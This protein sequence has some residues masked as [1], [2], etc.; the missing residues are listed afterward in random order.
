[1]SEATDTGVRRRI[2]LLGGFQ[3]MDPDGP[4]SLAGEKVQ[5]LLAYLLLHPNQ[6][7]PREVLAD[8]LFPE[9]PFSR[10]RRNL[11]TALSRMQNAIGSGWLESHKDFLYLDAGDRLWVDVWDFKRL[12]GSELENELQESVDLYAGD[13]VPAIYDDWIIPEREL[14]RNQYLSVL[15]KLAA[16]YEQ[17]GDLRSAL[18]VIRRLVLA[19]PIH[20]PAHADYL[21][22]LG[23]L[24]RYGEALSHYQYLR[25]LLQ[26][27][28][29]VEPIS[30]TKQVLHAIERERELATARVV[31][32]EKTAFVGRVRER[33]TALEAVELAFQGSGGIIAIEGE[34]G[35]GKSR[36]LREIAEGTRWRGGTF[37]QGIV[38][39]IPDASPFSPLAEA[40]APILRSLRGLQIEEL[41]GDK[42]MAAL[43]PLNPAWGE[44]ATLYK[45]PTGLARNRFYDALVPLGE[46]LARLT[47]VVIALDD[48]Q[49]AD[50]ALWESLD[51]L[52]K[53][54]ATN[55]GLLVVVY[56]RPG[57]E[58]TPGWDV[59]QAWDRAGFLKSISLDPLSIDEVAQL[60]RNKPDS[61]PAE[62][63]AWTGGNPF[64]I[65]E[66]LADPELGEHKRDSSVSHRLQTLSFSAKA[67]LES[68]A[69]VG[70]HVPYRLWIDISEMPPPVL[71]GLGDELV[72]KHLLHLSTDGCAFTH[73]LIRAEIYAGIEPERRRMLHQRAASAYAYHDSDNLRARA[74]HF[75]RAGLLREAAKT[76]RLASQQD[77][78]RFAFKEAQRGLE[79]ALSCMPELQTL[80][81]VET[82]LALVELCDIT[83]DLT[84]LE[85]A[86][87]EA[88]AG[89]RQFGN[90]N[91][92]FQTLLAAGRAADDAGDM[93]N[94]VKHIEEALSI[95][96]VMQDGQRE[97]AA[98]YKLIITTAHQGKL[99][100]A[101][102]LTFKA[103]E[104]SRTIED[105][106]FEGKLLR[107]VGIQKSEIEQPAEAMHWLEQSV[108]VFRSIGES[109]DM[110]LSQ[111]ILSLI[112]SELGMWDRSIELAHEL[113]DYFDASGA[114]VKADNA[115][116]NLIDAHLLTGN[117]AAARNIVKEIPDGG[118]SFGIRGVAT[119]KINLGL[120][121]EAEGNPKEAEKYYADA[122]EI[123]ESSKALDL[124][125]DAQH[126]LGQLL[127]VSGRYLEAIPLLE[128]AKAF[129]AGEGYL[130]ERLQS[131]AL[132]G[133]AYLKAGER[134]HAE[135]IM[136]N[137]WGAFQEGVPIGFQYQEWLWAVFQLMTGLGETTAANE[138]LHAAYQE[139]QR[140]A[141]NIGDPELRRGFFERV[142]LNHSIVTAYDERTNTL[143]VIR[144]PLARID[145][146]LGR[147]L[148]AD[149]FVVVEWTVNA[150]ED[151]A[152]SQKGE[153]RR[154]QVLRLLQEAEQQGAAP[155]D[156]DLATAL[157]VSRRTI[158]R[159]LKALMRIIP[160]PA[161]RKRKKK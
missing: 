76:Y 44:K 64:Y 146:P 126:D 72:A 71:A 105:K 13:L 130:L 29:G 2:F 89:A 103:L 32:E 125:A 1:M 116:L 16:I 51:V 122:I 40:L 124:V 5:S 84:R 9:A 65:T 22:L 57:I 62:V 113:I 151:E 41:L 12:A 145:S 63:Y 98:L 99:H 27:E 47:P 77:Q 39:E 104:L 144:V 109:Y 17:S 46:A 134:K 61:D 86:L 33:V 20:E 19:E 75:E 69:I 161:T 34:A 138:V 70:E 123:A 11:S 107:A 35:I 73:D 114:R 128:A 90:A 26:E 10:G 18:L 31:D 74:F 160:V 4:C 136:V 37:L 112:Y 38:G 50:S 28:L 66:W 15:E 59:V 82:N 119:V 79:R 45:L 100:D 85:S 36:F 68:A 8:L 30:E 120:I 148:E 131:E 7:I 102:A 92:L 157:G 106:V 133:L 48:V 58:N 143:R 129:R 25:K 137:A 91:L 49:W 52:A 156:D 121:A 155:T 117:P 3:I 53:S 96:R 127:L 88:L 6:T 42:T 67:A 87:S 60:T 142:P 118:V 83:G 108:Q 23:R 43:A 152:V 55:G 115:R 149:E 80:E 158:L 139:L 147:T 56:R 101:S 141:E 159:D 135:E 154:R 150:P 14:L 94:A 132:L 95:A 21:R 110:W 97:V 24:R 78:A 153:R 93:E 54:L 140:Q 111:L 81:R